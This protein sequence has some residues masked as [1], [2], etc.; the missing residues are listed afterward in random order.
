MKRFAV[1]ALVPALV[2]L[3][4]VSLAA[5]DDQPQWKALQVKHFTLQAGVN[6]PQEE[7]GYLYEGV[8][9]KLGRS[10]LAEQVLDD[11]ATVPP[12]DAANS[13]VM[14]GAVTSFDQAGSTHVHMEFKLY[15]VSD[16]RLITTATWLGDNLRSIH[17]KTWREAGRLVVQEVEKATKGLQPLASYPPAP[18]AAPAVPATAVQ[19]PTSA[20]TLTNSS[21]VEMVTAKIPE[22]VIITKI[23][24]TANN[25]DLSTPALADLNQKGVSSAIVK[26]MLKAPKTPA[27]PVQPVAATGPG[28]GQAAS[29][30]HEGRYK[31]IEIRHCTA[32][33]DISVTSGFL[34]ACYESLKTRLAVEQGGTPVVAEGSTIPEA[35][36][37]DSVVV[38]VK[39]TVFKKSHNFPV[40]TPGTMS[41][42]IGLYRKNDHALINTLTHSY[43]LPPKSDEELGKA[44]G[45]WAALE[46][47]KA[48]NLQ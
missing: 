36:A 13:V 16:H 33:Q 2:S 14:E 3:L 37:A 48:M 8:L 32:G 1:C 23:E 45:M 26:A 12:V 34:D 5:K 39:I 24:T 29:V 10:K 19:A 4:V 25:F 42:E 9:E 41:L 6:F 40:P 44:A 21:I 30:H 27:A 7:L 31:A 20:E 11:A 38:E 43:K 47:K 18:P 46:I 15:R 35:G 28:G 22:D 17:G